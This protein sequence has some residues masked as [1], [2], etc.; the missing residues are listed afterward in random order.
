MNKKIIQSTFNPRLQTNMMKYFL[1]LL[2]LIFFYNNTIAQTTIEGKVETEDAGTIPFVNVL[3][4]KSSDSTLVKGV[5]TNDEGRY[6]FNNIENGTYL[7]ASSMVGYTQSYSSPFTVDKQSVDIEIPDLL[8]TKN[9][10]QLNEVSIVTTRPFIEKEL[11]RTVI[12]VANSIVSSGSTGLEVLERAPGVIVDRQNDAISLLGKDGVIVQI[13]GKRTYLGMADVVALLR[14]TSSDNIDK[15]EL[16][17]NPSAR[18]DAE[19]NAGIINI[20]MKENNSIGTNGSISV[21]GGSGRYTRERGS[22]QLNH[23]SENFNMFGSY[24]IN[25]SGNYYDFELFR[26]Q[27]DGN[28]RSIAEQEM[29]IRMQSLG[30]NA[31]AGVDYYIGENTTIGLAWTGFWSDIQQ[32]NPEARTTFRRQEPGSIYLQTLSSIRM[33]NISSNQIGNLNLQHKFGN[34][35][36][37]ISADITGG[38]F[39]RESDNKLVTDTIIPQDASNVSEELVTQMPTIIDILTFKLDYNLPL[40]EGWNMEAG[41]KSSTVESDNNLTLESGPT[42]ALEIDPTLSNRFIY[43]EKVHAAYL[44]VRGSYSEKTELQLGLRAEL[45]N[46]TGNSLTLNQ[47]VEREYLDLFP[48]FFISQAFSDKYQLTFSYSYRIDRPSYQ[49]LN[50]AR[51]YLDPYSIERGN[52]FLNPQYT[53]AL[54]LQHSFNNKLFISF[55]ASFI[56]DFVL[57]LIQPIDNQKAER[58]PQNIGAAEAYNVNISFPVT[59]MKDWKMQTNL[60][61]LYDRFRYDFLGSPLEAENFSGRLNLNNSILLGK[62]WRGEISGW[63]S[64]PAVQAMF[65]VDWRGSLDVGIQKAFGERWKVKL[66]GQDLLH[67]SGLVIAGEAAN[68]IQNYSIDFD[69]RVVMLSLNYSFGNQKLKNTQREVGSEEEIQRTN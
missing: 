65:D 16:I 57:K 31:K 66:S 10:E 43:N 8:L 37:T 50:P 44:S 47:K 61:G 55:G 30:Q 25:Q 40:W 59:V 62:G 38:R 58:I 39:T 53:H 5:I 4:L 54:E 29:Y 33:S 60:M 14:S 42:G 45:T 64:T 34:S 18:Y 51:W 17:T 23:R 41:L 69:S 63:V 24:S 22:I 15:I 11:D 68:F 3:L 21:A 46:S 1:S 2:I 19:G 12:N 52:P 35:G 6:S 27:A 56:D 28:R 49:N 48:S 9:V 13:D 26:N 7:I 32:R 36:G 20:V 67:T